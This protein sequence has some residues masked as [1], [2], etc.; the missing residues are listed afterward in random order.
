M[1]IRKVLLFVASDLVVALLRILYGDVFFCAL[2]ISLVSV[3]ICV[4]YLTCD[5]FRYATMKP[6]VPTKSYSLRPRP[7]VPP[8]GTLH[9]WISGYTS[10]KITSSLSRRCGWDICVTQMTHFVS[11]LMRWHNDI[12]SWLLPFEWL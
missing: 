4:I 10:S 8:S 11:E 2:P 5:R 3:R 12:R 9:C 1:T 7:V 6:S